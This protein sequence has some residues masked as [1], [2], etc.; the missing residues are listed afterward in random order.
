MS[1]TI[2]YQP[3]RTLEAADEFYAKW[4]RGS[5]ERFLSSF[6]PSLV[7]MSMCGA[8]PNDVVHVKVR[9][10]KDGDP[11]SRYWGWMRTG[12]SRWSMI[13]PSPL[14]LG[15]CFTY[16]LDRAE[17]A[18]LG[19]RGNLVVEILHDAASGRPS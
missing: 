12:E 9:E 13:Q 2:H 8:G 11:Q 17:K 16:G 6:F 14:S 7:H 15:I 5:S 19:R 1:D 4:I 10:R 18:G 3:P